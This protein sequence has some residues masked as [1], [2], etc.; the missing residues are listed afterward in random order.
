MIKDEIVNKINKCKEFENLVKGKRVCLC[1]PSVSNVGSNLGKLI[2]SYDIV[3][4]VNMHLPFEDKC[5]FGSRTDIM[6]LGGWPVFDGNL[7]KDLLKYNDPSSRYNSLMKDTK[8]IYFIDPINSEKYRSSPYK[9]SDQSHHKSWEQFMDSFDSKKD[10]ISYE[11]TNLFINDECRN[12]MKNFMSLNN[13]FN[14][15]TVNSGIS[16]LISILRHEPKELFITGMN[17]YNYGKGGTLDQVFQKG[18]TDYYNMRHRIS[19]TNVTGH[20]YDI[21]LN[22]FQKIINEYSCIKLDKELSERFVYVQ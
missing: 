17:L 21:T 2:D 1:G 11:V 12:Y 6:L 19:R 9:D 3:C 5:D 14:M 4:R 15:S 8:L 16:S 22:F 20:V 18:S 10:L 13:S 7:R